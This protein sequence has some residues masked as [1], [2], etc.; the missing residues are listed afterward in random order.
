MKILVIG[1]GGR[2][3]ALAWRAAASSQV[4]EVLVAPGNAGTALEPKARNIPLAADAVDDLLQL[5]LAERI[6][7]TIVGPEA[8]LVA[9]IVDRFQAAGLAC[10]G[11]TAK[12]AQLEGSKAFAKA[13]MTRYK[14]PTAS[15]R[16]FDD[17]AAALEYV[18][19]CPFPQVIKADGLAAGKGVIIAESC[20]EAEA[21]LDRLMRNRALGAAGCE[22]VIEAFLAGEEASFIVLASGEDFVEFPT[23]QDHKRVADGD[24]GPN[25]GGMGAYSPAPVVTGAV[26]QRV[27]ETV[28][29]PALRGLKAEGMPY[30]GFLYAGLMID[31]QGEPRV[32][33][34]NCRLGDP[35]TQPLLMRM[36]SDLIELVRSALAGTLPDFPINWDLRPGLGVV[37]AADGYPG[38]YPKGMRVAGLESINGDD[39]KLFH[40]GTHLAED[41]AVVTTGGRIFTA[42]ALGDDFAQAR[43]AAYRLAAAVNYEHR[44]MRSDIGHRAVSR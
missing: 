5:A 7:L 11:P 36:R 44:Y 4:S 27:L 33:E 16:R 43:A 18:R 38:E 35:E 15:Y 25:T 20:A 22:V 10:F 12:A 24:R 34:F 28:I 41:G 26:R 8:P 30:T 3:H 42:C 1:S 21:A 14:I 6:D 9:G 32:L 23:S 17:H 13:F 29:R 19:Q 31:S 39:Q 2:E 37:L 40:A